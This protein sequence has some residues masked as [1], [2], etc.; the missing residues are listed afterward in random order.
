MN[1]RALGTPLR[2]GMRRNVGTGDRVVS[3]LLGA[4][5]MSRLGRPRGFLGKAAIAAAGS[6][7]LA[8]AATGHSRTYDAI[9]VSSASLEEGAGIDIECGITIRRPKEELFEFWRNVENLPLVME[10]LDSVTD[11]GNGTSHWVA[12]GPRDMKLEWD[13]QLFNERPGEYLAWHSTPG[14]RIEQAGAV[15][16]RDAG[17]Q[18]TE[19]LLRMRYTPPGGA[20]GFAL[21]KM[22]NPITESE[23]EQDLRRLKHMME[24]G[25]DI[26]TAG[27][28]TGA[29]KGGAS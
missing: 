26:S 17:D 13:A 1:Q 23:L 2:T 12:E 16:F 22:M 20:Y 10:H 25:V 4:W 15:H 21:A 28:P 9:G 27:Q 5:S 24:T 3:G 7:L 19:V 29:A 14:S 6:L 8:R 11:L 18:G